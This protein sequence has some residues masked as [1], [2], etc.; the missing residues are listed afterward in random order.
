MIISILICLIFLSGLITVSVI[1]NKYDLDINRLTSTNNGVKVYSANGKD[2]T[3]YNTNRSIIEIETLPKYVLDAFIDTEDKRFYSHNG[4]DLK[5]I[6]KA[7]LVNMV[8]GSK[9]QGASTIS[10]QLI[11]NTLLTNEKTYSR[12]IKE[13]VLSIK[14]EK[15]FEKDEILEMYL[16]TIYFGSNAYGIENASKNIF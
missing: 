2:S 14:M 16:N 12:K 10:Q 5:R 9:S 3:L 6:L 4:Y 7:G 8:N 1:Y 15:Q 11:K 13:L